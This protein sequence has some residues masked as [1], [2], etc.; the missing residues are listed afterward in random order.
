MNSSMALRKIVLRALYYSALIVMAIGFSF[1]GRAQSSTCWGATINVATTATLQTLVNNNPTNTTFSL[2]PGIHRLQSVV[3]KTGDVFVGQ[4][5]AIVSGAALLTSFTQSGSYWTAH[6]SVTQASSYPGQCNA[7]SPACI[8]PEDLFFNNVPKTRVTSLASVGPGKWYLNY[9]TG[10]AYM[11]DNPAGYTVE[12]SELRQAFYGSASSVQINNLTIEKYACPAQMGAVD[13]SGGGATWAVEYSEIRFNHGRGISTG[14]GMW[15]YKN[16]IHYNGQLGIGGG[17]TSFTVQSNQIYNNNYAGYS[18]YW[19]A[20]G[21]KFANATTVI[22]EY[23][24]AF[25]NLGPGLWNDIN[26]EGVTYN[27]NETFGNI[28]AGILSEISTNITVKG[29]YIYNDGS[30]PSG[31]GIWW[32]AGILIADSTNV[33]VYSNTVINCMNG[34]VGLIQSRGDAPNGQPYELENMSV[35]SN[36]VTQSNGAAAGIAID[37]SGP[38]NAVYTSMNNTFQGNTFNLGTGGYLYWMGGP[39]TLSRFLAYF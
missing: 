21:A 28:E 16:L 12:M 1:F 24:Y 38:T 8:Y 32:G 2:A 7:S 15:A 30:N 20:G 17:G 36:T 5:G 4:T 25:A 13:G 34:I 37:G 3:P 14:N 39:T 27:E 18:Y 26:S 23:N 11:G 31:T 9:S 19:E 35:D 33:S 10:T 29:N 22:V 6:V